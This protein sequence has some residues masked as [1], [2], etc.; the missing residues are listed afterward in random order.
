MKFVLV[1]GLAV[2]S[3]SAAQA[4][5]TCPA[6][7]GAGGQLKYVSFF[8][9]DPKDMVELAPDDA[10][11]DDIMDLTWTFPEKLST[12]VTVVCRY[13]NSETQNVSLTSGVTMCKLRGTIDA[14]ATITG[15]SVLTCQ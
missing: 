9:G 11:V 15:V 5:F 7:I 4:E 12:P 2:L 3:I 13:S 8:D 1:A 6:A 14:S 10:S